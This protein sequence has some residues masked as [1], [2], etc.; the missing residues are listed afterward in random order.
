[1][2]YNTF[3]MTEEA[4]HRSRWR[5]IL[6]VA[7]FV[8]LAILIYS[9]RRQIVDVIKNLRHVHAS[10]LLLMIPIQLINYDAYARMYKHFF[11]ILGNNVSYRAMYRLALELN[12]VNHIL[13]SGGISGI[14]YFGVRMRSEGV[15]GP[16]AT[17]AQIMK[18][19]L[20]FLSFQPILVVGLFLLALHGRVNNLIILVASSLITLLVVG[21]W[22]GIYVI[23]SRSRINTTLT[24]ITRG[25][26]RTVGFFR[27]GHPET[28]NVERAQAAFGELHENYL[29][30]KSNWRDLKLPFVYMTI[31]NLT[32]V[33]AVYV[34]YIAFGELVNF[35][36]VI[37][38]YAIANFAGLISVLPAGIGIY[39]GLM[40]GVLAAT[41]IAASVSIPVTIMYRVINMF[42]QLTPGYIF[43]QRAVKAGLG[44]A[45]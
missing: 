7:T 43:Y 9:L 4:T 12:F 45:K 40:T 3:S 31:A 25:L 30:I 27:R 29:Q 2:Q 14:S 39:E 24:L 20:L 10:A 22:L 11:K 5:S 28:I 36:A 32:E 6:T 35:G 33:A 15:S 8:A 37:L 44:K 42:V 19:F 16:K 18:F 34:V 13:P 17:L 23:G 41:G 1:L 21:T 38:A 26:N